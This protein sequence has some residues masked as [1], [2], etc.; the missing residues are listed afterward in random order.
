MRPVRHHHPVPVQGTAG[1]WSLRVEGQLFE[2]LVWTYRAPFAESQKI[3][4]LVAFYNEKVDL[5]VDGELQQR[6]GRPSPTDAAVRPTRV[7]RTRVARTRRRRRYSS[8]TASSP[9]WTPTSVETFRIAR[10]A[11][12]T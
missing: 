7:A 9:R 2:N 1:Y 4:G 5:Y 3:A 12:S 8:S 6:R 11:P 10:S